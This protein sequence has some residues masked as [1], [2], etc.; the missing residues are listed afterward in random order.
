MGSGTVSIRHI[1]ILTQGNKPTSVELSEALPLKNLLIPV[2]SEGK[3]AIAAA[4][5]CLT[6]AVNMDDAGSNNSTT[7][8][9]RKR[10]LG[11]ALQ[12]TLRYIGSGMSG[13]SSSDA[14]NDK[15]ED[16]TVPKP[17]KSKLA[18]QTGARLLVFLSG[19]PNTGRGAVVQQQQHDTTASTMNSSNNTTNEDGSTQY[20]SYVFDPYFPELTAWTVVMPP[21]PPASDFNNNTNANKKDNIGETSFVDLT[22]AAEELSLEPKKMQR[23]RRAALFYKEAAAAAATLGVCVDVYAVSPFYVGFD[24]LRPIS[25]RSGGGLVL[26]PSMEV[27]FIS[28]FIIHYSKIKY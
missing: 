18:P 21:P 17:N 28:N 23:N 5:D 9:K 19:A 6:P 13:S 15:N 16:E 3:I 12:A 2:D 22:H 10:A 1:P 25:I 8:L 20:P 27:N 7:A 4:L 14:T 24:V 26:Y 11:E